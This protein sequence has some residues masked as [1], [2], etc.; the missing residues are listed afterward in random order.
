MKFIAERFFACGKASYW[1]TTKGEGDLNFN[2]S[3]F[4]FLYI[5]GC[6]FDQWF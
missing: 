6:L 2:G 1:G 3:P 5:A 4:F